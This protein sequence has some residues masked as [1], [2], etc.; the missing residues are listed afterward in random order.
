M[1]TKTPSTQAA[2]K[3]RIR[4]FYKWLNERDFERC[5]DLI[6][7]RV[8]HRPSSVTLEQD[9]H[10]L[11]EFLDRIGSVKIVELSVELHLGQ[12]NT[13]YEG[14]DFALG[15]TICEDRTGQ[16]HV[17]SERWVREEKSWYTRSTGF[18]VPEAAE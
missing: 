11:S 15:K 5:Y 9:A 8:R 16:Q 3:R 13:L 18:V 12:P 17:F 1:K 10:S 2:L 4:Q 7:P 6:D 14:R